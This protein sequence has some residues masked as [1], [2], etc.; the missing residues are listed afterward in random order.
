MVILR[1]NSITDRVTSSDLESHVTVLSLILKGQFFR[2][3][4]LQWILTAETEK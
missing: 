1:D 3:S 4:Y 2:S